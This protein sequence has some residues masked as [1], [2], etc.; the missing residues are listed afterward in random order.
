MCVLMEKSKWTFG[1]NPPMA[2][3]MKTAYYW[4]K[5]RYIYRSMGQNREPRNK[6]RPIFDI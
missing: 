6:P 2:T 4:Y 5:N 3:V 1:P